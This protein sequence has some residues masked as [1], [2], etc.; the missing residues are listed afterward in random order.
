MIPTGLLLCLKCQANL[1]VI[2]A[3]LPH[4]PHKPPWAG[5]AGQEL[6]VPLPVQKGNS[7]PAFSEFVQFASHLEA[8]IFLFC[9][10]LFF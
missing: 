8:S 9:F 6:S 4:S 2:I 1:D 7:F 5:G 3:S 10:V